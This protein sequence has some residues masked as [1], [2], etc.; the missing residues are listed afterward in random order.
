MEEPENFILNKETLYKEDNFEMEKDYT[1]IISDLKG[2]CNKYEG[3]IFSDDEERGETFSRIILADKNERLEPRN[4]KIA[5]QEW[6][7]IMTKNNYPLNKLDLLVKV[8][9][10]RGEKEIAKQIDFG[11]GYGEQRN[12]EEYFKSII[13][14]N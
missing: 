2:L 11:L 12:A 9:Y 5:N 8:L 6:R 7:E 13:C 4:Y 10:C 1:K 3:V 14:P